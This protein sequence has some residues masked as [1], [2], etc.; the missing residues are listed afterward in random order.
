MTMLK[1]KSALYH[2]TPELINRP[3]AFAL[4]PEWHIGTKYLEG[5]MDD[6]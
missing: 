3:D 5:R 4:R 2:D 1:H 6:Y